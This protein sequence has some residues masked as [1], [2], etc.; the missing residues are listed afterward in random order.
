VTSADLNALIVFASGSGE[1]ALGAG[2]PTGFK[3]T[4]ANMSGGG[5]RVSIRSGSDPIVSKGGGE[6]E[7]CVE[8]GT[9]TIVKTHLAWLVYGD[10]SSDS[11]AP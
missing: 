3:V 6:P 10:V 1:L 4:V 9:A 11:C 5:M 8:G 2:V 7:I